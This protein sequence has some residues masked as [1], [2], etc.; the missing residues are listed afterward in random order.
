MRLQRLQASVTVEAT[1]ILPVLLIIIFTLMY[2]TLIL[3]DKVVLQGVAE[4]ALVRC[5]QL[6]HQPSDVLS[7]EIHYN[8]L[9]DVSLMG[10]SNEKHKEELMYFINKE[11]GGRLLVCTL[12]DIQINLTEGVCQITITAKSKISLPMVWKYIP[13]NKQ[14]AVKQKRALHHPESFAR[15]AEALIDTASKLKG[16]DQVTELLNKV[17]KFLDK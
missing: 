10:E 11:L 7:S 4:E 12:T 16:M 6:C 8:Q 3:H 1:F 17:G 2:M 5:N 15:K 14:F 13:H 9:L